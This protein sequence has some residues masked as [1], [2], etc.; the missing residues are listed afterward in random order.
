[1]SDADL[2]ALGVMGLLMVALRLIFRRR[3]P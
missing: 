2:V 3:H 1:M